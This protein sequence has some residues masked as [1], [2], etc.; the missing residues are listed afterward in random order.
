[1]MNQRLA[2]MAI[3]KK[4]TE[5]TPQLPAQP[6]RVAFALSLKTDRGLLK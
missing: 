1:L 2:T 4:V 6:N 5:E 3:N